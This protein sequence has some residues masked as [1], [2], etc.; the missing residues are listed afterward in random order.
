MRALRETQEREI[1]EQVIRDQGHGR[2]EVA[3]GRVLGDRRQQK[4]RRRF[5][6][7]ARVRILA[8]GRSRIRPSR[9]STGTSTTAVSFGSGGALRL[10][11]YVVDNGQR[12]NV[13]SAGFDDAPRPFFGS[14]N[15]AMRARV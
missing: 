5:V 3:R 15:S 8:W 4:S 6:V 9:V 7:H 10:R 2:R 11:Q 13:S 1:A 12:R 14:T